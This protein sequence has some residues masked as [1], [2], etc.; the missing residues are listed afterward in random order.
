M[1]VNLGCGSHRRD[2]WVGVDR[3]QTSA[4]DIVHDLDQGPW[5]F[6]DGSVD[7]VYA[8]DVFEHVGEP[9]LF[10]TECHRILQ[11]G[12]KLF[13]RV[14]HWRHRDAYT[15]PTHKRFLTESSFD[16][17]IAGTLLHSIHNE[18]YGA[19]SFAQESLEVVGGA[20]NI[21]LVKVTEPF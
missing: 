9:V 17:W 20:V 21:I 1:R 3:V 18:A 15:D 11:D 2:G 4:A 5:P 12:G 8:K 19:V 16:Y 7:Q 14:P 6:E 10:M 13:I